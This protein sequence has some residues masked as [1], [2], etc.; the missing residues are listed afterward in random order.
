M[1]F[2]EHLLKPCPVLLLVHGALCPP[3]GEC[4]WAQGRDLL[5]DTEH[6][7]P[8]WG[9]SRPSGNVCW[10]YWMGASADHNYTEFDK[11]DTQGLTAPRQQLSLGL[12]RQFTTGWREK[13]PSES[14]WSLITKPG[15]SAG[16]Q[17]VTSSRFWICK[18]HDRTH[19]HRTINRK[20]GT[21]GPASL[22]M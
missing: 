8:L 22:L 3:A 18:E 21:P 15:N 1:G 6:S 4:H 5:K 10:V 7:L 9:W 11:S 16:E 2:R 20:H 12:L 17:R 19:I 14:W 13:S